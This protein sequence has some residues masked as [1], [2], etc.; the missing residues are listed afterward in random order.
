MNVA[1]EIKRP[2]TSP[3]GAIDVSCP[4]LIYR[5]VL[6]PNYVAGVLKH[7]VDRQDDFQLGS[8]HN[9]Q[10]GE[11]FMDPKLRVSLYLKDLGPFA[12]PIRAFVAA[13]AS[14][15]LEA[16]HV[17]EP[18]VEPKEFEITAYPNGGHIGEHI[19]TQTQIKRVRILSCVY[20]FAATPRRFNGG[21]LRLFRFPKRPVDG[22]ASSASSAS[23]FVEVAPDTDTLVLFPS[24]LRHQV[25]PV[26]V[27]SGAWSDAR[28]TINCWVH[29]VGSSRAS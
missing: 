11:R 19:D 1:S 7:V 16:L 3:E 6:G 22:V 8:M 12:G 29:R 10:T 5:D 14:Q 26:R 21:E 20:Y 17:I 28:F 9:R 23:S 18:K 27:P 2:T 13:I 25:M 24:W 4:Y 15:A